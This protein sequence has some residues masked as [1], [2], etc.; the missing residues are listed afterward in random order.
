MEL[1]ASKGPVLASG[2]HVKGKQGPKYL[3]G[4]WVQVPLSLLAV[5]G[6]SHLFCIQDEKSQMPALANLFTVRCNTAPEHCPLIWLHRE[7]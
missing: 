2:R 4:S 5:L 3:I 7:G 6:C 1:T